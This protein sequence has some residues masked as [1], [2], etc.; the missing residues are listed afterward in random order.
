MKGSQFNKIVQ[1][2]EENKTVELILNANDNLQAKK[3]NPEPKQKNGKQI[4]DR[5]KEVEKKISLGSSEERM[6]NSNTFVF[7]NLQ[8]PVL[9]LGDQE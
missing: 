9:L 1:D 3:N 5:T 4:D 2:D 8:D 7:P 6:E